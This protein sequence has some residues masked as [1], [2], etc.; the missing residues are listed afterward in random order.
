[1]KAAPVLLGIHRNQ[2]TTPR[3][4]FVI[5]CLDKPD[6]ADAR[7]ANMQAHKSYVDTKPIKILLSGPLTSDDGTKIVGS[8]FMVE[9]AGRADVQQFQA[10][11]PLFKA[12]IW[13]SVEVRAFAKRIDNRD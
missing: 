13:D 5:H 3:M 10:N 12:Q 8:F 4:L 7:A 2:P 1:M 6:A 9:A 11:D